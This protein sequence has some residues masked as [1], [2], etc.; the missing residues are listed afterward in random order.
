MVTDRVKN[1]LIEIRQTRVRFQS[2]LSGSTGLLVLTV[3]AAALRLP[4]IKMGLWLDE[5]VTLYI[6]SQPSIQSMLSQATIGMDSNPQLFHLLMRSFTHSFGLGE[7]TVR[8]PSFIFG[9]L[10]VPTVYWL[11]T[12]V[13]SRSVGMLAAFF[14]AL[15][16]QANYFSCQ[17]RPYALAVDLACLCLIFFC[18]LIDAEVPEKKWNLVFFVLVTTGFLYTTSMAAPMLLSLG[19]ASVALLLQQHLR[20]LD[21]SN[22]AT[23]SKPISV[24]LLV[25][26]LLIPV[27][28][29]SPWLPVA[30]A[31]LAIPRWVEPTPLRDWPF[32]FLGYLTIMLPLPLIWGVFFTPL[33]LLISV[34]LIFTRLKKVRQPVL[35]LLAK[36]KSK[37]KGMRPACIVLLCAVAIPAVTVDY[38]TTFFL[39]YNRY[40]FSY[41]PAE[42][43]L[44]AA[45]MHAIFNRH[46]AQNTGSKISEVFDVKRNSLFALIMVALIVIN[47]AYVISFAQQP[48]SGLKLLARAIREGRFDKCAILLAPD[49]GGPTLNYY[50]SEQ[51]RVSH[52]VLVC[53]FPRWDPTLPCPSAPLHALWGTDAVVANT[54]K[55]IKDLPKEGYEYLAFAYDNFNPG[56][57]Q[58]PILTRI[59]QLFDHIK[60]TY[61]FMR[62][63]TYKGLVE[64][65]AVS[66]FKLEPTCKAS[67]QVGSLHL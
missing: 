66:I 58:V 52:H 32:A 61:K 2:Y 67:S 65:H 7:V 3:L 16:P 26:A 11:G 24:K 56:T 64:T 42:W 13:H 28:A 57:A 18:K 50:L 19:V 14:A 44:L 12:T 30:I 23:S 55:R 51:D 9:V 63:E 33:V 36:V 53:G 48:Q 43:V 46:T 60:H 39:G 31:Q 35:F 41:S 20:S 6:C 45:G 27:L 34:F 22:S 59:S 4:T 47:V 5:F 49:F 25:A 21:E 37:F 8:I 1:L 10:L 17:T 38:L 54:E 29:F 15:S 62:S 40:I